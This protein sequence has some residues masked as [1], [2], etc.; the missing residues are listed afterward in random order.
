MDDRDKA[1]DRVLRL[2]ESLSGKE[3]ELEAMRHE[4]FK[5]GTGLNYT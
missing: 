3:K 2:T 4:V 1:E 5:I